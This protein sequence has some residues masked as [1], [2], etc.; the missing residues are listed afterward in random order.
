MTTDLQ[1]HPSKWS[2]TLYEVE[3]NVSVG[4]VESY[5]EILHAFDQLFSYLPLVQGVS[6]EAVR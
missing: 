2:G 3:G 1:H 5:R 4:R 6:I